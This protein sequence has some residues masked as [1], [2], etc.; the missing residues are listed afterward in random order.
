MGNFDATIFIHAGY[1]AFT[2]ALVAWGATYYRQFLDDLDIKEAVRMGEDVYFAYDPL[3]ILIILVLCVF[4]LTF[5]A[6]ALYVFPLEI[7]YYVIP[8]A[9]AVNIVQL[10]YRY[11]RQRL[12]I[13]TL[14]IVGKSVFDSKFR[15][16]PYRAIK[17]LETQR[18]LLWNVLVIHFYDTGNR[19]ELMELHVRIF[20]QPFPRIISFIEANTGL[21]AEEITK[22][23]QKYDD[24]G[25]TGKY[26]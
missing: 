1:V 6:L 22:Q 10:V 19:G 25:A 14:G 13:K 21:I 5:A 24:P 2:Y 18:D 9:F 23:K 16:A 15:V 7:R 17:R 4:F 20:R 12:S 26:L 8:L 3:G 11:H